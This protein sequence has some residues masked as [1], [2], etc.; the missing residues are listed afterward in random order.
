MGITGHNRANLAIVADEAARCYELRLQGR[1][2]RE[3]AAETGL[4][5]EKVRARINTF[6]DERVAPLVDEYRRIENDKLDLLERMVHD[7]L[8]Q[9][10]VVVSHGHVVYQGDEPLLDPAPIYAAVDRL[11]RIQERRAKLNGLD[12]PL[13]TQV[14]GTL[15]YE[16]VGVDMDALRGAP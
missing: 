13:K 12:S 8:R 2:I 5:Y 9:K 4:G 16:I 10:H 6:A 11:I 7:T 15:T 1:T 3:I 14:S